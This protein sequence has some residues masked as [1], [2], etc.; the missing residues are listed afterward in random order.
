V[1]FR[2]NPL[3]RISVFWLIL[4]FIIL[5]LT[6]NQPPRYF[7]PL[8]IPVSILIGISSYAIKA[9]A[10]SR[11]ILIVFCLIAS[12]VVLVNS[13]KIARY[14]QHPEYSF[15]SMTHDV[16]KLIR[17]KATDPGKSIVLLGNLA[18]SISLE[19]RL[20]SIN[21]IGTQDLKWKVEKY[22]PTYYIS[23]GIEPDVLNAL[24]DRYDPALINEYDVYHN[25]RGEQKVS[26]FELRP[27]K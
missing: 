27:I 1:E 8:F 4:Y 14:L 23:L 3:A 10:N 5:M 24:L 15:K 25:Y 22:R 18:D 12:L 16:D 19:T 2:N 20:P 13:Y 26:L 21:R 6:F 11:N 17:S 9:R 7:V